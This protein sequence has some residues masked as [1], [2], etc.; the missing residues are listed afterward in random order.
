MKRIHKRTLLAVV[1]SIASLGLTF[2]IAPTG[3]FAA[4]SDATINVGSLYEPQNLDNT[5]GGGQGVTEA[6]HGNV[7]ESLF[8]LNDNGSVSNL[9]AKSYTKS[10]DGLTYTF[11]LVPGVKFHSGKALT[12]ADV[13]F[14]IEKVLSPTSKSARKSSFGA[15]SSITATDATTLV[16]KLSSRSISLIYNLSYP[17]VFNSAAT[18]FATQVDGT[19]PYKFTSWTKG[20]TLTLTRND[21]YRGNAA[22]NKSVV[23]HYFTD[24]TALNNALLTKAVDVITSVQSP[25]ALAQFN[26]GA[27]KVNNGTSTT[28][29]LLAFNDRVA[30]FNN[31]LVRK[32]ITSA[33]D[34]KKLLQAVWGS[35][36]TL[37]GSM[38]P[39]KDPWFED[40]TKVNPYDPTLAKKLLTEAGYPNGFTFQ[41]DAPTYDPHPTAAAFIKSELA[42]VGITVQIRAV[43]DDQWYND[44]YKARNFAATLQEHVNDR[45]VVW[46]ADPDF[47]W[48]YNNPK[49]TALVK[50]AETA[51]SL[52]KQTDLLKQA[53]RIIVDDAASDWIYLYP[54]IVVASTS[55]SGYPLNALNSQF[56]AYNIVKK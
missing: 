33:I 14:S 5:A 22:K 23:F 12:A 17:W 47:Y 42:K 19:G 40:L 2:A 49:V 7:Y 53:N 35:Y 6:L 1:A 8:K 32:A 11:K 36:G 24:A 25:D 30:P 3:A 27:F 28:K 56:Y 41:L 34:N 38:V 20:S 51:L 45:D 48:G 43:T 9:L 46:Y 13:K 55:L 16:I 37:T 39:P 50:S 18:A 31:R 15:I 52:R 44:V 10:S 26:S 29:L 4:T 21:A 54:Q